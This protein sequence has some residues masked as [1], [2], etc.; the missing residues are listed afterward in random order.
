[1]YSVHLLLPDGHSLSPPY[2][3]EEATLRLMLERREAELREEMKVR[4]SLTAL[5]H[6]LRV[7]MEQVRT[8][9][10]CSIGG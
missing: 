4:H 8:G 9:L 3:Q 6:E 5:L 7:N 2:R 1:M 10:N